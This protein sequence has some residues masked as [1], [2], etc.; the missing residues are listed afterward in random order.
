MRWLAVALAL[1]ATSLGGCATGQGAPHPQAALYDPKGDAHSSVD[2][3][4]E[5]ARED[6]KRVLLVMGANWCHDSKALAGWL[7]TPRFRRL[8]SDKY[9]LVFVDVGMPQAG[10]GVNL[11]IAKRFGIEVEG[12]PTVLILSPEGKLL[13]PDSA[14]SWSNA[15]QRSEDEIYHELAEAA[16]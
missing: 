14:T 1:C 12:T 13:N 7:E 11:D 2:R 4:L 8:V 3:A 10:R 15:S 16:G 9:E 5:R 6:G